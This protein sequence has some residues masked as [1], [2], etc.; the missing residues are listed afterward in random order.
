[1]TRNNSHF[2]RGSG[3]RDRRTSESK[4]VSDVWVQSYPNASPPQ[5]LVMLRDGRI[6]HTQF[7][8]DNFKRALMWAKNAVVS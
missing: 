4:R 5:T 1:M 7:G 3:G 8:P 6:I 2:Q